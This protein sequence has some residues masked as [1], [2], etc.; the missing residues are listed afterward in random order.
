MVSVQKDIGNGRRMDESD[1]QE[2]HIPD[3]FLQ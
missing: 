2:K 1:I 3:C